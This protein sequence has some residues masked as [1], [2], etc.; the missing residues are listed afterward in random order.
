MDKKTVLYDKHV[1]ANGKI[2][3]FGGFLLPVQYEAGVIKEHMVVRENVGL[4]DVSHMGE[5][6]I[7]GKD[8][9]KYMNHLLTNRYDD[10]EFGQARYTTMCN[11]DGGIVDDL[12]GY[13]ISEDFFMLVPNAANVDKDF[14][15][16]KDHVIGDVTLENI[17]EKVGQIALQGPNA[18]EVL[19]K[20]AKEEDIPT[21]YYTAKFN[22]PV[23]GKN[24]MISRTGYTGEFGYEIYCAA[25][26]AP[27]LWDALLDAGKDIGILPCGLGARDTLRMEAGMPLYGQEMS[28][29]ITP[30][31]AG[32]NFAVKLKKEEFIGKESLEKK[33]PPARKR[34]GLKVTGRGIIREHM[35]I[36]VGDKQV[37]ES[38]S[39]THLP[40]LNGAYAVA[41]LDSD[42]AV[43]GNKV[44]A[45]VRGRRVEAEVISP[46]FYTG[47]STENR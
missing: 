10:M 2:V 23:M 25:E 39:G 30:L 37:G 11:E 29:T 7:K 26:D 41:L 35:P 1:A 13:R 21:K 5:V 3:P 45:D 19:L 18:K 9:A 33:N 16:M 14:A 32:L 36:Y 47:T 27:E 22:V 8:A 28:D 44:E 15:W 20:L 43:E 12:I 4:F 42:V 17:S 31:E 46:F 6:L 34:V 24:V 40:Y 38:T